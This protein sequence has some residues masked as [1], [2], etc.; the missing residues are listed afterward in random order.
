MADDQLDSI[1]QND[2]A[3][4][5]WFE[6]PRVAL[7]KPIGLRPNVNVAPLMTVLPEP[8]GRLSE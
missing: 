1:G 5:A 4:A 6:I 7:A 8:F 2:G 3:E